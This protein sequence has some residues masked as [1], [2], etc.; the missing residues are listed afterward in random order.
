MGLDQIIEDED[1][2]ELIYLRKN[3]ALQD[4]VFKNCE[5]VKGD[6]PYEAVHAITIENMIGAIIHMLSDTVDSI[7]FIDELEE[8][9]T[10]KLRDEYIKPIG[11]LTVSLRELW[12]DIH[13]A[14]RMVES[15]NQ[16]IEHNNSKYYIYHGW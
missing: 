4:Y 6:V 13:D 16:M 3:Y 5:L 11:D 1:G 10:D 12:G 9:L 2:N 15:L 7:R 8:H 14:K